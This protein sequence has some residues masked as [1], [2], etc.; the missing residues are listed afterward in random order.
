MGLGKMLRQAAE[1]K[2]QVEFFRTREPVVT[3]IT[4][5]DL[6]VGGLDWI[7]VAFPEVV[8]VETAWT[9][10]EPLNLEQLIP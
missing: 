4:K 9:R 3:T 2:Q 10:I 8:V 6:T 5:P 1:L 7:D